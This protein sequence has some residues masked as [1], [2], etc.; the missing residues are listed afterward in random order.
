MSVTAPLSDTAK[1]YTLD[2]TLEKTGQRVASV[3]T[4][5]KIRH[6]VTR[7]I[8]AESF[9]VFQ[10]TRWM[11]RRTICTR[12]VFLAVRVILFIC[13]RWTFPRHFPIF[14]ELYYSI[15]LVVSD[16]FHETLSAHWFNYPIG[17]TSANSLK[18]E[19]MLVLR[20]ASL[21]SSLNGPCNGA[22][23][24]DINFDHIW[25]NLSCFHKYIQ[26]NFANVI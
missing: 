24:C 8:H 3:C 23:Y 6:R 5:P 15:L 20:P 17:I 18:H 9:S 22:G 26:S 11:C 25:L 13:T 16:V 7:R 4:R 14:P 21:R 2:Y 10:F 19:H 1:P 12:R